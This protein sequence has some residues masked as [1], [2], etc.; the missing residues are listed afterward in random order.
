M[1]LKT[2]QFMWN[3]FLT[4]NRSGSNDSITG[5]S[6]SK[7]NNVLPLDVE[8]L[9]SFQPWLPMLES[10]QPELPPGYEKSPALN[11]KTT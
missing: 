9:K 7:N 5:T 6:V 8:F 3:F 2:P 4:G 11:I 10:V 1:A